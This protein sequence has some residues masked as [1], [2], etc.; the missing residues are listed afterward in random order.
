M[1]IN[2]IKNKEIIEKIKNHGFQFIKSE[3]D[4]IGMCSKVTVQ[5]SRN[6]IFMTMPRVFLDPRRINRP[7]KGCPHCAQDIK[8]ENAYLLAQSQL[9]ENYQIIS[10]YHKM[11]QR[12]NMQWALFFTIECDK[13]HAYERETGQIKNYGC[14]QCT[15]KTFVGQERVRAIFETVFN[16]K[17][18]KIRPEWLKYPKTQRNL[19][20]DGYCE[21]LKL[22]FEYQGRQHFSDD[23][24]F[25]GEYEDQLA[26][27]MFKYEQ[28]QKM[29]ICLIHINQPRSY[30]KDKFL[31]SVLK[32]CAKQGLSLDVSDKT[33]DFDY[34]NDTHTSLQNY[35]NFKT[36]VEEKNYK[37]LSHSLSTMEDEL[38][39]ECEQGHYFKMNGL[40]FKAI[41]NH[42]KYRDE[43]CRE[44][45]EI[46]HPQKVAQTITIQTCQDFAQNLGYQ[47]LSARYYNVN[48]VL[49]W[50]CNH[51]HY[52]EKTWRQMDRNKT[53]QYCPECIKQKLYPAVTKTV[54][55][56][57]KELVSL[58]TYSA[59]GEKR[60]IEWLKNFA[61]DNGCELIS[62][63]YLGMDI[64][65]RFQCD[66]GHEFV[67]SVSN[68]M[69]KKERG[70]HFCLACSD[71]TIVTLQ[72]CEAFA[73]N[74]GYQCL[75][76]EYKNVNTLMP[77]LCEKGH[78]FEKTWRQFQ[79]NKT[80]N[81]CPH[82]R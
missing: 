76:T 43:A 47:C 75:A 73:Q 44:C 48:T 11:V 14:P 7:S 45:F 9:Q 6:H 60:D 18:I 32:D 5:C 61:K 27:D 25:A 62:D 72:A 31:Q 78:A 55:V 59:T 63:K 39:F 22:A 50:Q 67:S 26:R 33:I 52:F 1:K 30:E 23:T 66:K 80:G 57:S 4:N 40:N 79:R 41:Y 70:T 51:G 64:K 54:A 82:C 21:T 38:D 68:L 74:I 2:E 17:F 53:G 42:D 71:V 37:L 56:K 36:I 58:V 10:V 69:D 34:I 16:E 20:L 65:H 77:W 12:K 3:E 24:E 13:G 49:Q 28:C 19:E 29:G 15:E 81:Y 8:F 35:E 46:K